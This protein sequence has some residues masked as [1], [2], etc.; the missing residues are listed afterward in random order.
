MNWHALIEVVLS[1]VVMPTLLALVTAVGGWVITKLPGPLRDFLQSATHQRDLAVVSGAMANKGLELA[2]EVAEG[3]L[4]RNQAV[5]EI[6]TYAGAQASGV[7]AKVAPS[8]EALQTRA[9]AALERAVAAVAPPAAAGSVASPEVA[10]AA[11]AAVVAALSGG[12]R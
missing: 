10:G 1:Q 9:A 7:V 6:I 3:R 2:R 8:E 11:A 5:A 4:N 12:R